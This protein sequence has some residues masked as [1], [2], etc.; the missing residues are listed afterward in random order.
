MSVIIDVLTSQL[1][2]NWS[3]I[4]GLQINKSV[5]STEEWHWCG[6]N[7][8]QL[9]RTEEHNKRFPEIE[10]HNYKNPLNIT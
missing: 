9:F 4:W 7:G 10:Q 2:A 5:L 1:S 6:N 3:R 8:N